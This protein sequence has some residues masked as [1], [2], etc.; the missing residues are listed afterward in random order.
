MSD[1]ELVLWGTI[2]GWSQKLGI[3]E[4]VLKERC[5]DLPMQLCRA[6]DPAD[7]EYEIVTE[8]YAEP[9]VLQACADLLPTPQG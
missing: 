7:P 8:A 2:H 9:D 3:P 6:K 4:D 1:E 5:K